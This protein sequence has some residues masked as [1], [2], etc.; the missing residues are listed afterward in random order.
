MMIISSYVQSTNEVIVQHLGETATNKSIDSQSFLIALW[1]FTLHI[2][3]N[4]EESKKLISLISIINS[5]NIL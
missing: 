2:A 4:T 1:S 3:P 5:R